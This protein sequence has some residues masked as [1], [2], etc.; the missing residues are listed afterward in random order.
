MIKFDLFF[1]CV[2]HRCRCLPND[3]SCWPNSS[4][5][6]TFNASVNGRLL[7]PRSSATPCTANQF[8]E[9]L[10][11]DTMH[12]W[13]NSSWRSD[14]V[15]AMQY[16]Q[17]ENASCSISQTNSTCI[18]GSVPVF[19]VDAIWPEHIQTTISYASAN[20]LRLVMKTSGH[21][22]L[23]RSTAFGSLL[24]WLHNMKNKTLIPQYSSCG[25]SVSNAVLLSAGVQWGDVYTWLDTFNLTVLGG[26]SKSVAAAGGYIQGGGHSP[27]SRWAGMPTDQVLQYDVVT[28][29]GTRLNVSPC[30]NS[31]LFWALSGGGPGTYGVVISVVLRTFPT[32]SI[33]GALLDIQAPNETRYNQLIRD[34][35]RW[36]PS[37]ADS[38]W[39]GYFS[40]VD[41]KFS[42]ALIWPNGDFTIANTIIYQF[43]NNNT[44]LMITDPTIAT[45]P[46]LYQLYIN[47][48]TTWDFTGTNGLVGSRLIPERIVRNQPDTVAQAFIQMNGQSTIGSKLTISLV[49]GGQAS[50]AKTNNSVNPAW[51]TALLHVFYSQGWNDDA[52]ITLQQSIADRIQRK[53]QILDKLFPDILL[54]SYMNEADPNEPRW[55]ERFFG[56]QTLY[57]RLKTVKRKY[58]PFDLFICK[59]CVGSDDWTADLNCPITAKSTKI[60]LKLSLLLMTIFH[61]L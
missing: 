39:S 9:L 41:T 35:F 60:G 53:T 17:W 1:F 44:D 47:V 30:E 22:I 18:Q 3:S 34:F 21:D 2:D 42:I 40:M 14:Q 56:S 13:S 23:G 25:T 48:F 31:D 24:M 49:A 52:S 5:W 12:Y 6:Q 50:T 26:T 15:G 57:D 33:V 27:L 16:F 19:A 20:N 46:S 43:I 7:Q 58:D 54:G 38:G 37:L 55:Q 29:A 59:T 32:P 10:C 61:L 8:N 11:N 51:R 28:A 36:L 4:V 45:L